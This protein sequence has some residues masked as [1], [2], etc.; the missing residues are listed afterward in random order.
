MRELYGVIGLH[1]SK[2]K[3]DI[4]KY[5]K[6]DYYSIIGCKVI[7]I[8]TGDTLDISVEELVAGLCENKII[9]TDD[10]LYYADRARIRIKRGLVQKLVFIYDHLKDRGGIFYN[11][12]VDGEVIYKPY[13]NLV[14][15]L[16]SLSIYGIINLIYDYS[17]EKI[18]LSVQLN[19]EF[20]SLRYYYLDGTHKYLKYDE[21]AGNS[22]MSTSNDCKLYGIELKELFNCYERYPNGVTRI[23][24]Y[25]FIRSDG[26]GDIIIPNECTNL[27]LG[28]IS[29][30]G[31]KTL[32]IPP[33]VSSVSSDNEA[34]IR[35]FKLY[36]SNKLPYKVKF[37]ICRAV[38]GLG[39]V[40]EFDG[41]FEK[42]KGLVIY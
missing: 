36:L 13:T 3:S 24:S 39:Y 42:V 26:F 27:I 41:D 29:L 9:D 34:K 28:H 15:L 40:K 23:N 8:L 38:L 21:R 6:F 31:I 32:V 2:V 14:S 5:G 22:Y 35:G 33:S 7:S 17:E 16:S 25:Y 1:L 11:L 20:N 12:Y 4:N 37:D 30:S 19:Y 10:R 18:F